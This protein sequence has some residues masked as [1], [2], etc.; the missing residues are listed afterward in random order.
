MADN[1]RLNKV[2][3]ELN[4]SIDRA[5]DFLESKGIEIEKRPTTKISSQIYELLSGEFQTDASKKVASNELGVAK[6]KEKEALRIKREIELEEK[7]K[8]DTQANQVIKA[9]SSVEGPKTVGKIDL[10]PVKSKEIKSEPKKEESVKLDEISSNTIVN[11][12]KTTTIS[13]KPSENSKSGK[14]ETNYAKLSGPKSTGETI[15]LSQFNKEKKSSSSNSSDDPNRA[16]SKRK[17]RRISK[18]GGDN[19]NNQKAKHN[20]HKNKPKNQTTK[21]EPTAEEV[22]KQ[23]R[24]TLEKLQGKSLKGKGAKYRRDKRD[25]HRQQ[26]EKELEQQEIESKTLKVTE[27]VTA[28]EVASMMDVSVTEIISACMSLGMMVT[29]N[30]RLDAETLTIVA[31]EFGYS[32]DFVTADIEEAIE[33]VSDKNEDLQDRAP[34]VTV[35][36]HVD[37]GKTSLLDYIREENVIAGES[38]G[39][40]QHIGAYGVTLSTGQ[41][42]AFLDTP[43]HEAFTAMRARGAQVTDI[44]I[45]I[46]A[47]DDDIKP[48]TKEA[49]SHAQAAGVPIVF[50]INK[51]D[52]PTA[53]P[54]KIKEGLANMNLMVEDWGGKIQ[55]Q[56]ISAKNGDGVKELLEK[57]LLEAELLELKANPSKPAMGTIV[58]AFLDKG[59]GYVSTVLVQAGTLRIGDYVLAGKNSGKVKAMH[60]ERGQDVSEAGPSTPISILGLDGAP[61]AGDKFN[62]FNDE[63]EAKQIAAKRTQLQREQSVRTQKHITLDEIGR[64]IALGDFKEL[65]IILKGDVDG[66]VEALTD[67]FQKLSTDEIQ[68]NI[69]HKAVGAITESDVLLASASEAIII[70]FNVRPMGNAR[71]I[72]EKEEIDIRMYSIIYDAINDL[73]DAMEGMLSP[74]FKEEITGSAEIRETFKISK[75]GTIAGCMVTNG[76]IYRS[77]KIRVIR[78][79]V[80]IYTGELSSLKRFKDDAKEVSKGYDCGMQIKGYNDIHIGDVLEAFQEVAVKKKL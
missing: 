74:D 2:L 18:V 36:G 34:I 24:E 78:D 60:D 79:S 5:I 10:D 63:R 35:M 39:I 13:N 76:K 67:S 21:I 55:S 57:V 52:L 59:R 48:Q 66:S 43:G 29:M 8:K 56:D 41:K 19:T 68:V 47:A 4:I 38:G 27:F 12:Q 64:R 25:Q 6:Q 70:G 11:K 51:V 23:V 40:T 49:I 26:T 42:I 31:E 53:N 44:A 32:V 33:E 72:A 61:Q 80:I 69:I 50:A 22:Q 54:D 45:I 1:V 28:N 71:Q 65:N 73:K 9:K 16:S 20:K 75:I 14:L 3:R 15:D 17:R 62:V 30:Q 37:H 7:L 77:S 58:E 46:I